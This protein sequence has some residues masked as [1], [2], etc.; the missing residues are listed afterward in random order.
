MVYSLICTDFCAD[1]I[2]RAQLTWSMR[3]Q[4]AQK[5]LSHSL[6]LSYCLSDHVMSLLSRSPRSPLTCR[7]L[8]PLPATIKIKMSG[9]L[10]LK[11]FTL[12][13]QKA[14]L[15]LFCAFCIHENRGQYAGQQNGQ[16][17][18]PEWMWMRE[19]E[20]SCSEWGRS[21]GGAGVRCEA[22][23]VGSG[24][25]D[26]FSI[27]HRDDDDDDDAQCKGAG[28]RSA[29]VGA[30]LVCVLGSAGGGGGRGWCFAYQL[31]FGQLRRRHRSR[32]FFD[33]Q[34]PWRLSLTFKCW[35]ILHG[36][37]PVARL[38]LQL[39]PCSHCGVAP[40]WNHRRRVT[41]F[42]LPLF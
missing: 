37:P 32:R 42:Y 26:V 40:F 13:G 14:F 29:V 5:A 15:S 35:L 16:R 8:M 23:A 2:C 6:F 10:K 27:F 38:T 36:L 28:A 22:V 41:V 21:K 20:L 24:Y 39:R 4:K 7:P 17:T 34:E 31:F 1:S 11:R 30:Q 12:R 18:A 9:L 25:F 19:T 33:S 3:R